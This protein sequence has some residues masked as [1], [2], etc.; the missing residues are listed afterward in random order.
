MQDIKAL[1]ERPPGLFFHLLISVDI[2]GRG[3][4]THVPVLC[5]SELPGAGAEGAEQSA[6]DV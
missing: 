1:H 6:V 5:Q 4:P 2:I 3:V